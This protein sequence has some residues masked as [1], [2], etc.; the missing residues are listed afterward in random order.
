MNKI[1]PRTVS[2]FRDYLPEDM[3][4]RQKM[5]DTIRG[6]FERFGFVPWETPGIEK[7]E[8]LTGGD[9][10]FKKEIFKISTRNK[11]DKGLALRFDLTVPLARVVAQYQNEMKRPFKRYQMGLVWRGERPQ[12]GRYREFAQ[13]DA[14][15]VGSSNMMADSEIIAVIYEIMTALGIRNFLIRVNNRKILDGLPKYIGFPANRLEAVLRLI[16]KLDKLGW[17]GVSSE[18]TAK[19]KK[20]GV[21]FSKKQ[22]GKLKNFLEINNKNQLR[23][24]EVISATI[25]D[26]PSVNAGVEELSQIAKNLHVLGVRDDKWAVDLSIARGFG[27]YTGPIFECVIGNL[28]GIGSVF[29]GG[30]YDRL[31]EK[32]SGVS[33]P[34]TG[35]SAGIDRLF[36]AMD[37]LNLLEKKKTL[38]QIFILN[39]EKNCETYYQEIATILRKAGFPTEIYLGKEDTLRGQLAYALNLIV[40]IV[41]I[42]GT[43]EKDKKTV[44]IKDVRN[45]RQIEAKIENLIKEIRDILGKL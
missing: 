23:V 43:D 14:D 20:N 27:Y 11:E 3:I 10:D 5:F 30:R 26:S 34:A 9:P 39:F 24:L 37:K 7:E 15:I 4:P 6:V 8:I 22:I 12:S 44:Q 13:C 29:G 17:D 35:V 33:I 41:I 38:S 18:L 21:D 16:D 2:G 28:A 25:N 32:F 19:N 36:L 45:R 40:P 42:A 31:I 1:T